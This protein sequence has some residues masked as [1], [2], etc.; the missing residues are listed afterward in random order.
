[1]IY[2]CCW[3]LGDPSTMWETGL[4]PRSIWLM[5]EMIGLFGGVGVMGGDLRREETILASSQR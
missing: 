4:L 5:F 3:D 2:I 1:M